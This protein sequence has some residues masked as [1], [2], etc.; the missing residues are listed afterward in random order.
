VIGLVIQDLLAYRKNRRLR[1]L[2]QP[3]AVAVVL[4]TIVRPSVERAIRSVFAQDLNAR[5]HLLIGVDKRVGSRSLLDRVL[6]SCPPNIE[7]TLFDPG[8]STSARHGGVHS[9]Y[10]GGALRTILTFAANSPY[11]AYLDDDDWYE[12]RHLSSLLNAIRGHQWAFSLRSFVNPHNIETMCVDTIENVGPYRGVYAS[13]G[14]FACPSSLMI[15]KLA[16]AAILHLWSEAGTPRGDAEDRVFFSALCRHT[17]SYGE[18]GLATVNCVIKP[19]DSN[20]HI[21]E[22]IILEAGYPIERLRLSE[23]HGFERA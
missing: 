17:N 20:H 11:V 10:F 22:K 2:Q 18:T 1:S 14:G 12:P 5:I 6:S 16:C 8:Y 4:Q 21:R 7:V 15:D 23:P 19:E 9:N 3:T 13:W